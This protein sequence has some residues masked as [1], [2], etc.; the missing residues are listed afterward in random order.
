MRAASEP[1]TGKGLAVNDGT[2]S[3]AGNPFYSER[4][5]DSGFDD[6]FN[7]NIYFECWTLRGRRRL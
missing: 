5:R 6:F 2:T 7:D 3:I 1:P 4:A